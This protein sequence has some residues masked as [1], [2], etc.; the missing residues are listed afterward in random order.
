M[1]PKSLETIKK[2]ILTLIKKEV[3]DDSL[4]FSIDI[5]EKPPSYELGDFALPCFSL[6]KALKKNPKEI[7]KGI[8]QRIKSNLP[9]F[10]QDVKAVGPYINFFLDSSFLV[11]NFLSQSHSSKNIKIEAV[12]NPL[13]IM[14]EYSS[15]N[16]NKPQHLGHIRNN[17]LG[18]SVSTLLE[19]VGHKVKKVNLLNDRGLGVSKVIYA[20][21]HLSDKKKPDGKPDHFVGELYNL[22]NKEAK[23]NSGLEEEAQRILE[24]WEKGDKKIIDAWKKITDFVKQGYK[25]T[26]ERLGCSFDKQ[27]WESQIYN[28]GKSIV[29]Q[30]LEKGLFKKKDGAVIAEL[31]PYGLPNKVLIKRN[32]TALYITQDIALAKKKFEDFDVDYSIYVVASEQEL[33]FKQLFKIIELLDIAPVDK[34]YH[35][36]YGM[37]L[38]EGGKMKSREGNIIDADSL[39]E[40]LKKLALEEVDERYPGLNK[41]ERNKRAERIAMAALKFYILRVDPNRDVVF[42]PKES[43]SFQGETGPYLLYTYARLRSILR[44]SGIKP[45]MLDVK[46]ISLISHEEEKQ[47]ASL[48]NEF[49]SIVMDSAQSFKP[50]TLCRFL[51]DFAQLINSYYHEKRV[52]GENE[53]LM[54]ARLSL[55]VACSNV[56]KEGL[57][58]LGIEVL[59]EM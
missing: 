33:Y 18:M 37:F 7:A 16:T 48:G 25:E 24:K 45:T 19:K 46:S 59:E 51:L 49:S 34:L 53:R 43:I 14:V 32:G 55:L 42:K 28:E 26:Y 8:E 44:K 15:P 50:S 39:I 57:N 54:K 29:M 4:S 11:E 31:E 36:S 27:Y 52:I 30:G 21:L 23:K 58:L 22:F 3:K 40:E 2:D 20:Y 9:S 38:L 10:L 35:L 6:S 13:N 41:K 5:L 12:K 56:L 1:K 17:L 47:I